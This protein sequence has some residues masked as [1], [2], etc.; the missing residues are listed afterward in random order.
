[1]RLPDQSEPSGKAVGFGERVVPLLRRLRDVL[2]HRTG[3]GDASDDLTNEAF[4]RAMEAAESFDDER[5]LWPWLATIGR[6]L[7]RDEGRRRARRPIVPLEQL[8]SDSVAAPDLVEEEALRAV[9]AE[10]VRALVS[11]ALG[12]LSPRE[13]RVLWLHH[14]E[15][16]SLAE[17]AHR[18]GI[19]VHATRNLAHKAR[20]RLRVMLEDARRDGML[21][22]I[23]APLVWMRAVAERARDRLG[24][25]EQASASAL[26]HAAVLLGGAMM[27]ATASLGVHGMTVGPPAQPRPPVP[28]EVSQSAIDAH[29]AT[30]V[31]EPPGGSTV[32]DRPVQVD[33]RITQR[34]GA[35]TP[36]TTHVRLE[37]YGPDGQ[38]LFWSETTHECGDGTDWETLPNDGPL[39]ATC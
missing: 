38:V 35:A 28:P 14:E 29:P 27:I 6:N 15:G 11:D 25:L 36:T 30:R 24:R 19:T 37:V 32:G 18:E 13:R 17:I 1:M 7:A 34:E 33:A 21:G 16:L 2:L 26:Q 4:I 5:L 3:D 9:R 10:Q 22:V 23:I 39:R 8:D 12:R 31:A 20:T